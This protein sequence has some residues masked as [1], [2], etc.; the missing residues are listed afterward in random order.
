[1][2][3]NEALLA[4]LLVPEEFLQAFKEF[5]NKRLCQHNQ[6]HPD[7]FP[8]ALCLIHESLIGVFTEVDDERPSP[9]VPTFYSSMR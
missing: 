4:P 7:P 3:D 5:A 8:I 2:A 1:M 6:E 9:G